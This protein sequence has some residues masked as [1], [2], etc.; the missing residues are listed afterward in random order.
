MFVDTNAHLDARELDADRAAVIQRAT[1]AGVE[2]IITVVENL[3]S[4]RA[5]VSLAAQHSV[6]YAAV[7][8]HPHHASSLTADALAELRQL[9]R[10]PKVVAI[11]EIGLDWVRTYAPRQVQLAAFAAQL[12]LADELGLPVIIHNRQAG[13]DIV[14]LIADHGPAVMTRRRGVMHAFSGDL[15]L[16]GE[17]IA[18][19]FHI[20]FGGALT[21]RGNA[22]AREVA[23]Q[24][25]T[26]W[27]LI[28]T[29]APVLPPVP[30][31]GRRNEPAYVT[32]VAECLAT[33]RAV[34]VAEVAA[35]TANNARVLFGL[36]VE[37]CEGSQTRSALTQS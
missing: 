11:G 26:E 31:R 33:V 10:Q 20:S 3:E 35:I 24:V 4:S 2:A 5:A 9:A 19:G 22:L 8:V 6:V 21:Y 29:D 30:W 14:S 28:E 23:R 32:L 18:A 1:D 16:A 27:L 34:A 15:A 36:P 12:A 7:G 25:P 37:P 17:A 13:S